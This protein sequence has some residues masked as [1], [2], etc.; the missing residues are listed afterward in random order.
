MGAIKPWHLVFCLLVV[1][2]IV[3]V[4]VAV[5]RAGRRK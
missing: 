5:V 1:L 3:G 2:T 4:A